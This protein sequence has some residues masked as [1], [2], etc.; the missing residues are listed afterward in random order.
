MLRRLGEKLAL[1]FVR[2]ATLLWGNLSPVSQRRWARVFLFLGRPFLRRQGKVARANLAIAFPQMTKKERRALEKEM[3]LHFITLGLDWL[4]FLRAPQDM[5]KRLDIPQDFREHCTSPNPD[6]PCPSVLYCTLHQGNWELEAHISL[7]TGRPGAVVVARFH[8]EW[9]N[10]LAERL[11]TANEDTR[12][13]PAEGAALGVYRALREGRNVGLLIDQNISPRH[14]GVFLKFF[15]LPAVT[16]P[17]P[18]A[19]ARRLRIPIQVVACLRQPDGTYVMDREPLPQPAWTYPSDEALTAHI[20]QAYEAL[21]RRHPEQ[22]LW[23]YP[24][25]KY[26]PANISP[27]GAAR[28]PFYAIPKQYSCPESQLP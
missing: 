15:G 13:I 27:E 2:L 26:L 18:A 20:L 16:S 28:F 3:F 22:Y 7:L 21:I 25:W 4:H 12:T 9:L 5:P 6:S 24:R 17:M 19:I 23:F 14:G 8:M 11:R 10:Q 1:S